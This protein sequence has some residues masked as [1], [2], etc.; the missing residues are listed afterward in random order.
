MTTL[1][2]PPAAPANLNRPAA[3]RHA[4]PADLQALY[5][6]H[7]GGASLREQVLALTRPRAARAT[8]APPRAA[9]PALP[10]HRARAY[11]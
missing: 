8:A 6:L 10:L 7:V 2:A 5:A 3:A 11:A 1:T 9:S 4:T